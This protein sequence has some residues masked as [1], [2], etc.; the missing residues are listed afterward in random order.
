SGTG[1]YVY[2]DAS[3]TVT[4][5][6]PDYHYPLVATEPY[7]YALLMLAPD[8]RYAGLIVGSTADAQVGLDSSKIVQQGVPTGS[9]LANAL[10]ITGST[11]NVSVEYR[12]LGWTTGETGILVSQTQLSASLQH[13]PIISL[14]QTAVYEAPVGSGEAAHLVE[15]IHSS[16]EVFFAFPV[17]G[18][19]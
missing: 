10:P 6:F 12:P 15:T 17:A 13:E 16:S 9:E 8:G 7:E 4:R 11:P 5:L 18:Y 3:G 2:Q 19:L 14:L 1:C